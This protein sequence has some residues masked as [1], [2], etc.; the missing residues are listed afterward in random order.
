M[1]KLIGK[2][3][4]KYKPDKIFVVGLIIVL[5]I[6]FINIIYSVYEFFDYQSRVQSGND[7]WLQVEERIIKI[8]KEVD[9]LK[10]EI[11]KWKN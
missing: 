10:G 6:L 11:E 5:I 4:T 3:E 1:D 8:E 7:R 9:S 2:K